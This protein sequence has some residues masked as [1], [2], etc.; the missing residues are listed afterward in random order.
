MGFNGI[1]KYLNQTMPLDVMRAKLKTYETK[2]IMTPKERKALSN[3]FGV[4]GSSE[5][6]EQVAIRVVRTHLGL[7]APY[8]TPSELHASLNKYISIHAVRH[9]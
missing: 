6:D 3:H 8:S 5:T 1:I 2:F 4:D 7:D 9:R